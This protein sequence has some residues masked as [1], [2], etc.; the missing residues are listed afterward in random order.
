[1]LSIQE[2]VRNGIELLDARIPNW[3]TK[4]DINVI[5]VGNSYDKC[6]LGQIFGD[7]MLG[8]QELGISGRAKMFGF[9]FQE[10]E[11]L[12]PEPLNQEWKRQLTNTGDV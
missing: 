5:D 9:A 3:K 7:F 6:P 8:I 10:R 11:Y 1:M 2:R 4:I 12:E